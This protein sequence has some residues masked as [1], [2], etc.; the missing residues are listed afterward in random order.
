MAN[1]T[2]EEFLEQNPENSPNGQIIA[3]FPYLGANPDG[4]DH[5]RLLGDNVFGF[6]DLLGGGDRDYNDWVV[7]LTVNA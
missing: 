1:G 3:Y 6:E 5:V 7:Q 4:E 2:V